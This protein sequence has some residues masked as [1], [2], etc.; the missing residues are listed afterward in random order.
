MLFDKLVASY[1][2]GGPSSDWILPLHSS[3]ASTDQKK[4]F[5]R[6]PENIRKASFSTYTGWFFHTKFTDHHL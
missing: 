2:F 6:P 5:L 1:R 3:V 4:V